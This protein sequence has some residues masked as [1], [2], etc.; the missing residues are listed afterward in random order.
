[1]GA[2]SGP[3][4]GG[5]PTAALASAPGEEDPRVGA[6]RAGRD[7][8]GDWQPRGRAANARKSARVARG[9]AAGAAGAASRG[10]PEPEAAPESRAGGPRG[11]SQYDHAAG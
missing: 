8:P 2:V 5:G 7:F 6:G 10:S 3:R 4:S 9:A 11:L 1:M